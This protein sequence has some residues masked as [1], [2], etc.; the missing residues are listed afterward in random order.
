MFFFLDSSVTIFYE[1]KL[2]STHQFRYAEAERLLKGMVRPVRLIL[3][4]NNSQTYAIGVDVSH[5]MIRI[6]L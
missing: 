1:S 3:S 4:M 6:A 2:L 5:T